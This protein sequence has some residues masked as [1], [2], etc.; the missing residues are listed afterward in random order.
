[1][2]QEKVPYFVTWNVS[3]ALSTLLWR[4]LHAYLLGAGNTVSGEGAIIYLFVFASSDFSLSITSTPSRHVS[5]LK[6]CKIRISSSDLL[7]ESLNH[8]CFFELCFEGHE[9]DW[10]LNHIPIYGW[11]RSEIVSEP[12]FALPRCPIMVLGPVLQDLNFY[13]WPVF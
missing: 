3:C 7:S 5:S 13:Y 4:V 1:M 2:V 12:S 11:W 8:C 6:D 9:S 10:S